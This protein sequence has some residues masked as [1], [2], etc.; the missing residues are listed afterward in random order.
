MWF[1]EKYDIL[2]AGLSGSY[3]QTD[4][5]GA[6]VAGKL[7]RTHIICSQWFA[8]FSTLEGKSRKHLLYALQGEPESGLMM[9][10]NET[11]IEYLQY[12]KISK[13]NTSQLDRIFQNTEPINELELRQTISYQIPDLASKPTVFNHVCDAFAFGYYQH[14]K[15]CPTVK[16]LVSDNAPEYQHIG[17]KH[18][19]CW[20]HDARYY[21]K[22]TPFIDCNKQILN[23]FKEQ[24]WLFYDSLIEYKEEPSEELKQKIEQNFDNLFVPN[25]TY[26]DLNN[27]IDRTRNDKKELLTVLEHPEIPLHNNRSELAARHQVRKRDICLHTITR[28]GTQLQDAFMSIIYTCN[29]LSVNAF[30]YIMDRISGKNDFYLPDLIYLKINSS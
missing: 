5:T 13:I 25:T 28:L 22:L 16:I 12:F 29:L 20:V 23:D 24:Y 7:F 27:I 2:L 18:E 11:T 3:T 4:T 15:D 17:E 21:N 14:Q 19:L 26:S 10:Y 1:N 6:I 9:Y 8:V 30:T